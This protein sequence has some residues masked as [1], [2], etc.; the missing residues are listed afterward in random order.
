MA[1]SSGS[2]IEEMKQRIGVRPKGTDLL[3]RIPGTNEHQIPAMSV[4]D[5]LLVALTH[6]REA[7]KESGKMVEAV[8]KLGLYY[9]AVTPG[10]A[11]ARQL[12]EFAVRAVERIPAGEDRIKYDNL[13][14][15]G[16]LE[17]KVFWSEA[18]PVAGDL[19]N[20]FLVVED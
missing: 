6:F 11:N 13:F 18:A 3:S 5:R 14:S 4:G 9:V 8:E 12:R 1:G 17:N 16:D 20:R 7:G 10:L 15:P 2:S 19:V